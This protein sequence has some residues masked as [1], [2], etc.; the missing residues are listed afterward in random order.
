M[1]ELP[2]VETI[3]RKLSE[4]LPGKIIQ[5]VSVQHPK[6]FLGSIELIKGKQVLG[7]SR[8]AKIL[9]IHLPSETN[10]L[11][12][13]KMTGQLIYTDATTRIGGGHPTADWV[14]E[15][16]SKHTRITAELSESSMLFF[17]DQRL[18]GWWKVLTDTQVAAEFAKLGLDIID[19]SFSAEQL[20]T[21]FQ[22]T[23]QPVKVALMDG[24]RVSGVGNIY[25]CDALNLA[26]I[27]PW[28]PAKTLSRVESD[29]L[30]E[31]AKTV[32]YRGIE[33]G[34]AT[35]DDYRDVAGFAGQYQEKVLA[36]GRE[37][38]PCYNCG[39]PILKKK[40]AGRGTYFC[41]ECQK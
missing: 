23:A 31:A 17:N 27:N 19:P 3:V 36:Y 9:R 33:L 5:S 29:R 18:F 10:I 25:A 32:I 21:V 39:T 16:P 24:S 11:I 6:S 40:L 7:V 13:L 20:F 14:S 35:I 8:R 30:Y 37:G 15:L 1:P 41:P 2:E 12:H 22:R 4:H 34:G 28:R 26:R 38:S